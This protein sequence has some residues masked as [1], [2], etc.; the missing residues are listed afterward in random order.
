MSAP[1]VYGW[2]PGALRPMRSG[3]GLVV[4]VRAP[5]GRLTG[6]QAQGVADLAQQFGN[7]LIDLSAR[8]NLQLRGVRDDSHAPLID[9][10]R[11]LGLIDRDVAAETRRNLIVAPF[12]SAE[13]DTHAIARDLTALLAAPDAPD[14]PSKFGFAVDCGAVPVLTG[15]SA[16]IRIERGQGGLILRAD[17]AATGLPVTRATAAAQAVDLARW[18][19][20]NGGIGGDGR[21]RMAALIRRSGL[22]TAHD[23]AKAPGLAPPTPGPVAAG[24]LTGVEFGQM[25]ASALSLFAQAPG[26][27]LTPW[28]MILVEGADAQ[29]H[30]PALITDPADPRLKVSVC[31]GAPACVQAL[32]DTR[33][34]AR[35][36]A[37]RA[38]GPLHISGCAKGCAHPA[39]CATT[40]TAR[41]PGRFDLIRKGRAG[42]TPVQRDL[43]LTDLLTGAL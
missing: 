29:I 25:Q 10:L 36:L 5:L 38:T 12:W 41:A 39:P 1:K 16:D 43:S 40:L 20:T 15:A 9:G 26:L 8:A 35:Q 7:G 24:L 42:D 28:R 32:S 37:P 14:L 33:N 18:F 22:P 30:H 3:D 21:G 17:G 4:R 19:V 6:E 27:R 23:N 13:D 11:A 34:T 31:S 2:C